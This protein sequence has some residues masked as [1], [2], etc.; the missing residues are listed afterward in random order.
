VGSNPTLTASGD[1]DEDK[2]FLREH[3]QIDGLDSVLFALKRPP[4]K[5]QGGDPR[6][7]GAVGEV[8]EFLSRLYDKA[9]LPA[10]MDR[11]IPIDLTKNPVVESCTYSYKGPNGELRDLNTRTRALGLGGFS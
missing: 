7:W 9:M 2:R 3:L 10:R 5:R 4:W 11:R 1:S 8:Q 6:F